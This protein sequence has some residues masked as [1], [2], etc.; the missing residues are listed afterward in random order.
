MRSAKN[1][2]NSHERTPKHKIIRTV[3]NL[4]THDIKKNRVV[5]LFLQRDTARSFFRAR[6][7]PI[8]DFPARR[9]AIVTMR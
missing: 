7:S 2:T 8:G 5:T 6:Q 1:N 3:A 4:Y 9:H